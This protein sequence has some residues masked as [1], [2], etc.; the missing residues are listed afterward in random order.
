[1]PVNV[2]WREA[3]ASRRRN[4]LEVMILIAV[5][6]LALL[7]GYHFASER[8][9][10]QQQ[11]VAQDINGLCRSKRWTVEFRRYKVADERIDEDAKPG[12]GQGIETLA[13]S[14]GGD[15]DVRALVRRLS[16]ESAS[17]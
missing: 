1:M 11:A 10:A 7:A 4:L 5:I 3:L 6:A 2:V 15:S 8:S 17:S 12:A 14:A 16:A 9:Q 13:L